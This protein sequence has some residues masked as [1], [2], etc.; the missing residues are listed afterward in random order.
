MNNIWTFDGNEYVETDHI[1]QK[2]FKPIGK[3]YDDVLTLTKTFNIKVHPAMKPVTNVP[4]PGE[5]QEEQKQKEVSTLTFYKHRLDKNSMKVLFWCLPA[6][7]G[8]HTLKFQNNG[9]THQQFSLLIDY[10]CQDTCPV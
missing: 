10:L 1:E 4:I 7:P 2:Q 6:S 3:F 8:I 9:F 5:E